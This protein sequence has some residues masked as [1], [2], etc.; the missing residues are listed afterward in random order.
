V[1]LEEV[2]PDMLAFECVHCLDHIAIAPED[3]NAVNAARI[4]DDH[5][6]LCPALTDRKDRT[7]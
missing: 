4:G 7:L 2:P 5:R 1:K 3:F 6:K